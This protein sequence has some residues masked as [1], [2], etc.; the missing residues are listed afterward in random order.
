MVCRQEVVG[1]NLCSRVRKSRSDND[2][3]RQVLVDGPQAVTDPRADAGAGKGE[4]AGVDAERGLEV[5][6]MVGRQGVDQANTVHP[7]SDVREE[8]A[9]HRAALAARLERPAGPEEGRF[10]Q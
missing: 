6:E 2:K 8:V 10:F 7:V 9:Y 1:E 3:R 5:I 4:R